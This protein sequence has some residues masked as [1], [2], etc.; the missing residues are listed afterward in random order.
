MV[1]HQ[2][3]NHIATI[4]FNIGSSRNSTSILFSKK[5]GI[6]FPI[7]HINDLTTSQSQSLVNC[8]LDGLKSAQ[9]FP[10]NQFAVAHQKLGTPSYAKSDFISF[11]GD[12]PGVFTSPFP[13]KIDANMYAHGRKK[14]NELLLLMLHSKSGD[15]QLRLIGCFCINKVF[16]APSKRWLSVWDF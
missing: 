3:S 4:V 13:S 2:Y 7:F 11:K 5:N 6:E 15:H 14:G 16:F 8:P 9:K 10:V 12:L 1:N